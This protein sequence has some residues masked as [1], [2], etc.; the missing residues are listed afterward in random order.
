MQLTDQIDRR[1]G[2]S[3]EQFAREY[4]HPLRPVILT[5]AISHWP[6]LGKWTPQFFK[7]KYGHLQVEAE[8]ESMALGDLI[9]RIAVSTREHP[10]PYLR[11]QLLAA[12]PPSSPMT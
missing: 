11:N 7:E 6:A 2:L 3:R 9:D 1:T 4:L 12:W 8:G 5:D 10:A